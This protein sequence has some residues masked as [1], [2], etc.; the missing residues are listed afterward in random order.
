MIGVFTTTFGLLITF[1][2]G[3]LLA[4]LLILEVFFFT[5]LV[6]GIISNWI[7]GSIFSRIKVSSKV[8]YCN[9]LLMNVLN[10]NI[11][12]I[13]FIF[14]FSHLIIWTLVPSL[15]NNNL[16]LDTIEALAWG[17]NLS[18]GFNKHPPFSAFAV[19]FFYKIFGKCV[20]NNFFLIRTFILY[21]RYLHDDPT[22]IPK[23]PKVTTI[24]TKWHQ[25]NPEVNP[26]PP[27]YARSDS[28]VSPKRFQAHTW[29]TQNHWSLIE[30]WAWFANEPRWL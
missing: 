9:Y 11:N 23:W 24:Y 4:L 22:V 6:L 17:S 16:P 21:P 5:L 30:K 19:E 12:N 8:N 15:T 25:S 10:R 20:E 29:A 1:D 27:S 18:W 7:R 26:K 3:L 2:L 28:N 13:F 14:L